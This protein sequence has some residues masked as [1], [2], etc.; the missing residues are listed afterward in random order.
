MTCLV[1]LFP[2]AKEFCG[3][4]L[5]TLKI[6]FHDK[7]FHCKFVFLESWLFM[8][9]SFFSRKHGLVKNNHG[10]V[11]PWSY[12]TPS[13]SSCT[14]WG[15]L[16]PHPSPWYAYVPSYHS[17]CSLMSLLGVLHPSF[18]CKVHSVPCTSPEY[19][20]S[21]VP[22]LGMFCAH[23]SPGLVLSKLHSAP[24]YT[25][26]LYGCPSDRCDFICISIPGLLSHVFSSL[27]HL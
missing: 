24:I 10:W 1:P 23:T 18:L 7:I 14:S 6:L 27:S 2:L 22:L 8:Y 25:S 21:L 13:R 9:K 26:R 17:V 5:V 20:L 11:L 15:A 3:L 4:I 16:A 12:L 19:V